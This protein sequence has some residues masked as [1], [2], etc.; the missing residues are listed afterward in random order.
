MFSFSL[1]NTE[2]NELREILPAATQRWVDIVEF[3]PDATF[4]IDLHGKVVAWNRTM[5]EMSGVRGEEILGKDNYEYALPFY[6]E[7]RPVVIDLVLKSGEQIPQTY[8]V[9]KKDE[10]LLICEIVIPD[11]K[12]RQAYLWCKASTLYD[13]HGDMTGAIETVRDIT[14]YKIIEDT[15]NKKI[16]EQEIGIAEVNDTNA[17]LGI[18]LR[19]RENEKRIL[20]AQST[21][22]IHVIILPQIEKLRKNLNGKNALLDMNLPDESLGEFMSVFVDNLSM[23]DLNLTEKEIQITNLINEGKTTKEIMEI[24]NLSESSVMMHRYNI[25]RKFNFVKKQNLKTYL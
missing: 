23:N 13:G 16:E 22:N 7:R 14:D 8:K 25:R 2:R 5:E 21:A 19:K 1:D 6:G 17:A 11:F 10:G 20:E 18:L 15:V 9:I 24:L 4:V 12:G 3:I